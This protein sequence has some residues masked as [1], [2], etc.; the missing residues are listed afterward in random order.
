MQTTRRSF[1]KRMGL[2]LLGAAAMPMACAAPKKQPN[3]II[4][5]SDDV[6][7]N[8]IG[9][10]GHPHIKTPNIDRMAKEGVKFTN[11]FLT[12]SS[13]S[14]SRCSIMTGRYPHSTGA[15]ELHMP[16]PA[17]QVVFAGLLKN[18][19]YYTASSGKWHM[20]EA[21]KV[22]FDRIEEGRPSGCEYWEQVVQERP[23]DK[24]FFM[25]FASFDAHRGYEEKCIPNPHKPEDVIVPP[26]LPDNAETRKDLALYYDEIS[27]LDSYMGK[28]FKLL[29][30]QGELDN[31]FMLFLGDNGRPFPRCKTRL[32]D[33][34][35][36]TPFIIRY[37]ALVKAGSVHDNLVSSVDIAPTI[38]DLA[39]LKQ[40][41]T[42]QG[43]SFVPM[44]K[45]DSASIRDYVFAEH[46]WHDYQ[47]HERSVRNKKYLYIRNSFPQFNG[48]PPADAVRSITYR[49]MIELQSQ[50]KLPPEQQDCFIAPRPKEELY[51][52]IQDPDSFK[53]LAGNQ[54]YA[55]TLVE[56]R[57][58]LDNWIKQTDDKIP[59]NPT[60][61][62]FDRQTGKK[63]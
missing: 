6:S 40:T 46:N 12:I 45:K 35:I 31:T 47:A 38:L 39:G 4:F 58:A 54:K 57:S 26:F 49:K 52:I 28:V 36:Q 27:R 48:N 61:D 53:N 9:A 3:F 50:G 15:G 41:P 56:M 1:M 37:P 25:W 44:L 59:D 43:K 55:S 16:L 63:L 60:P 21:A 30:D 7:W 51:D 20:G 19:G 32:Y 62:K 42:F 22:N 23:K 8:D 13:C 24:P 5:I 14:P 34:G 17:D 29:E 33:S 18:A 2:S 10:Y 11:A